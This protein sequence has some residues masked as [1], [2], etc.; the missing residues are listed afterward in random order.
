M[1]P[2]PCCRYETLTE[3]AAFEMCP[4]CWWEDD[5]QGNHDA[6]VVRGG[7]N[8]TLSL[9]EARRNFEAFGASDQRFSDKV[10]RPMPSEN[11]AS[12]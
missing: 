8:G 9:T 4:V 12:F 10:R 11:R 1:V 6:D 3:H 5:G 7:P 2:C